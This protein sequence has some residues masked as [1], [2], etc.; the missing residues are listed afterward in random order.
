MKR[1]SYLHI[2]TNVLCFADN[3]SYYMYNNNIV[4]DIVSKRTLVEYNPATEDD[5]EEGELMVTHT[6]ARCLVRLLQYCRAGLQ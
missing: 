5:E 2:D 3:D 4:E 6:I 1:D